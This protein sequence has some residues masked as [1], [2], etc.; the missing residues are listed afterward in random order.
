[1]ISFKLPDLLKNGVQQRK[2]SYQ[3]GVIGTTC[4]IPPGKNFTYII[5]VKDQIGSFYYFPSLAFHKAA[6]AFGAIRVWSRPRIPVPFPSPDGDFWLLAGDWYK[7][8]HYVLRRLLEAGRNIPFPDG[9]LI[10]G[11]GWGGNT[12]TV[13]PVFSPVRKRGCLGTV[14]RLTAAIMPKSV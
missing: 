7:T 6:G 12:F 2:N 9:V 14:W 13:Q 1:M 5:Q 3:D 4:P 8:N 10:N 11:R